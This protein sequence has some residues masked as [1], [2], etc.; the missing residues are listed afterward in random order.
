[1]LKREI[2]NQ[3][4]KK[5]KAKQSFFFPSRGSE[6][7]MLIIIIIV[8]YTSKNFL[9]VLRDQKTRLQQWKMGKKKSHSLKSRERLEHFA[10]PTACSAALTK[11]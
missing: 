8:T 7:R 5:K 6:K 1:M 3:E 2:G 4:K 11:K 10:L 9:C